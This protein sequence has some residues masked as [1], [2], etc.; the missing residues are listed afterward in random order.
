MDSAN[1]ASAQ[2]NAL[3]ITCRPERTEDESFLFAVYSGTRA[4]ELVLTGWNA[5]TK[6]AFLNAQF[7]AMRQ[8]YAR[9]YPNASFLVI[10]RGDCPLG[11]LVVERNEREIR[12]VDLALL[13]EA[14]GQGIGTSLLRELQR[15]AKVAAKPLRL[16][17]LKNNAAGNWYKRLG[18]V[19]T[20]GDGLHHHME[21][22]VGAGGGKLL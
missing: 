6:L 19:E 11:R 20:P 14:R 5:E 2:F 12:L 15:E 4:A 7:R 17:V 3:P 1:M 21:W 18:F 8:G 16:Q 22:S 10:A 13:P 9:Q